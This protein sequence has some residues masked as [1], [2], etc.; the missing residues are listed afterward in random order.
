MAE[1]GAA[2]HYD[3]EA[4]VHDLKATKNVAVNS[5]YIESFLAKSPE[6]RAAIEKKLLRRMDLNLIPW[7]T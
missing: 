4:E 3:A 5:P 6:E 1:K 7:M 2:E